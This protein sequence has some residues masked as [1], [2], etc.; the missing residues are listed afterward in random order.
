M[1]KTLLDTDLLSEVLRRRNARVQQRA[2]AYL[3]DHERYTVSAVTMFEVTRGWHHAGRTERA[4]KF[5]EWAAG[6]V[7]VLPFDAE[8]AKVA[9]R[10]G[11]TLLK[12]GT[13]IGLA[14]VLIA[15]TAIVHELPIATG[16]TTHYERA[17]PFGLLGLENWR[18]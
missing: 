14:D 7:H 1:T 11:G 16:N 12:N 10:V 5:L 13:P 6:H 4:D 8:C 15:A 18:E 17:K 2:E 3:K 9:G